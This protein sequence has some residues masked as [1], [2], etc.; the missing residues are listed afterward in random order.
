MPLTLTA[1]NNALEWVDS[2]TQVALLHTMA[3]FGPGQY[4]LYNDNP[5]TRVRVYEIQGDTYAR[6]VPHFGAVANGSRQTTQI[7]QFNVDAGWTVRWYGLIDANENFLAIMPHA[8]EAAVSNQP[9]ICFFA[10]TVTHWI[11][12]PDHTLTVGQ[13]IMFLSGQA[14]GTNTYPAA[15]YDPI[16]VADRTNFTYNTLSQ[17]VSAQGQFRTWNVAEITAHRFRIRTALDVPY[18]QT[19]L[20]TGWGYYQRIDPVPF[21]TGGTLTIASMRISGYG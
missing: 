12:A 3:D 10:D 15:V 13:D 6:Q 11:D 18:I 1:A 19:I 4:P 17:T 14:I 2:V 20:Y 21:T 7:L 5:T 9:Q 8:T 16:N